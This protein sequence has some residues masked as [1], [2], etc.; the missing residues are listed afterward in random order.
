MG[1]KVN[2][3]NPKNWEENDVFAIK[4]VSDDKEYDGK[5]I[6]IIK[7]THPKWSK[8]WKYPVFRAKITKDDKIPHTKEELEK[9]EYIKTGYEHYIE[10]FFPLSN[11]ETYEEAE[12][13]KKDV[14]Y[15]PDEYGFLYFYHFTIFVKNKSYD[16]FIYLG[17]FNL[18]KPNDETLIEHQYHQI[19][20][21]ALDEEVCYQLIKSFKLLNNKESDLYKDGHEKYIKSKE[22]YIEEI[23]NVLRIL[24][25]VDYKNIEEEDDG[26][27][28]Y[29]GSGIDLDSIISKK[30]K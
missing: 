8:E 10:R 2:K 18:S 11:G 20:A 25:D 9:L 27:E 5:Y 17:N 6:I 13:R 30:N 19:I 29:I 1:S 12:A 7:G 14:E 3:Q 16:N 24:K 15:N 23:K 4:I 21:D 22:K 28:T 26:D